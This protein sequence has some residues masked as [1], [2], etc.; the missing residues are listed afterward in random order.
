M[1]SSRSDNG[2]RIV[3]GILVRSYTSLYKALSK[4]F[5]MQEHGNNQTLVPAFN[6]DKK[7]EVIEITTAPFGIDHN[8]RKIEIEKFEENEAKR[9]NIPKFCWSSRSLYLPHMVKVKYENKLKAWN[10][11]NAIGSTSQISYLQ[12]PS[13]FPPLMLCDMGIYG[14]GVLAKTFI[15]AKRLIG[16][17]TGVIS[18]KDWSISCNGQYISACTSTSALVNPIEISDSGKALEATTTWV[19][20]EINAK[21]VGNYISLL[22]HLPREREL[23][24][25][26]RNKGFATQNVDHITCTYKNYPCK[27]FVSSRDIEEGEIVGYSYASSPNEDDI[28]ESEAL[29]SHSFPRKN[30]KKEEAGISPPSHMNM[31]AYWHATTDAPA[32]FTKYGEFTLFKLNPHTGNIQNDFKK[33]DASQTAKKHPLGFFTHEELSAYSRTSQDWKGT[34]ENA[35]EKLAIELGREEKEKLAVIKI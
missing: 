6:D 15:P 27:L 28:R 10:I 19:M 12:Q 26:L 33:W 31:T 22:Q 7:P 35:K 14:Y 25:E 4:N 32:L 34:V 18:P 16:F 2:E 8:F 30:D 13:A 29:F 1:S 11:S 17:Y 3:K 23:P 20:S 21:E 24:L 5:V 9:R